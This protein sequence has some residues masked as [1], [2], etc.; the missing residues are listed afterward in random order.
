MAFVNASRRRGAPPS[1]EQLFN[2]L[3]YMNIQKAVLVQYFA[4]KGHGLLSTNGFVW[5]D[6]LLTK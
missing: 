6:I 4:P 5:F 2:L 3:N 1:K